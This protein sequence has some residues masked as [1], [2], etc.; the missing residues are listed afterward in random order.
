LPVAGNEL[1]PALEPCCLLAAFLRT[2]LSP[3]SLRAAAKSWL[4]GR[5]LGDA[6][7]AGASG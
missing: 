3:A 1:P 2:G 4:P 6:A 7:E 5:V